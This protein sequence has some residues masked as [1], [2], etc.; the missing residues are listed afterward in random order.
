MKQFIPALFVIGAAL[1]LAG[2]AIYITGWPFAPLI[3]I[4]GAC[5]FAL[6]QFNSPIKGK[7]KT[8]KRLRIQ[9]IFGSVALILAGIFMFTT[10]GNEWMACLSIAAVL[11]LYTAFRIP[12][13]E[14]KEQN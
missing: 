4:I 14:A 1:L 5:L 6:A 2:A 8:L 9:Q 13:E 3:Y 10:R 12:A 7:S 11:E